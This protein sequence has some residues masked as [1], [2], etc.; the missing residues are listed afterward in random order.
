VLQ[1]YLQKMLLLRPHHI[2]CI[3]FYK[4]LGYNNDFVTGMNSIL[5]LIKNNPNIKVN[6][7]VNC[8][9]LCDKCPNM[10]ANK[11]CISN[12]NVTKLDYNTLKIYNLKENHEYIFTE[13]I[14]TLYKNFDANKFH[15]ICSSCN[16]YKE[17]VC[18]DTIISAQIKTWN[19]I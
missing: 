10:K 15:E 14:N 13:I 19:F 5:S 7:I 18:N 17:G 3:F 9:N 1:A 11:I 8:D 6:L 4:G 12:E 2:N 16:W